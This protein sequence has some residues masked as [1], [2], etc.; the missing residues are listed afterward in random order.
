MIPIEVRKAMQEPDS[1]GLWR[2]Y[3]D[4]TVAG[5]LVSDPAGNMVGLIER[6]EIE[7]IE[8]SKQGPVRI[9]LVVQAK[10]DVRVHGP[11]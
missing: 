10:L 5:T 8:A 1:D 9:K 11:A 3:S 2:V 4:G 7:P 6:M